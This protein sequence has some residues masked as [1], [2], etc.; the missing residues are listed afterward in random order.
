MPCCGQVKAGQVGAVQFYPGLDSL[1]TALTVALTEVPLEHREHIELMRQLTQ[2]IRRDS[3]KPVAANWNAYYLIL[4]QKILP[5]INCPY[6]RVATN[7][8]LGTGAMVHMM[9]ERG[10]LWRGLKLSLKRDVAKYWWMGRAFYHRVLIP[11]L[12]KW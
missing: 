6:C 11:R 7:I 3:P 9:F 4:N 1:D 5:Y 2:K 10:M 12:K 8:D